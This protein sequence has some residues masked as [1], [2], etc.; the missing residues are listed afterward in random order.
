M[1]NWVPLLAT[2]V[3]IVFQNWRLFFADDI[4]NNIRPVMPDLRFEGTKKNNLKL[5][6]EIE[7]ENILKI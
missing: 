3:Y 6:K 5:V 2:F 1:R 4:C 7:I